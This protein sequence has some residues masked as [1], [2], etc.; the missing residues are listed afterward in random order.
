[1]EGLGQKTVPEIHFV[2]TKL[3]K[4][5]KKSFEVVRV[6]EGV[7]KTKFEQTHTENN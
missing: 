2:T 6:R 7:L 1:L 4:S 5:K 3:E